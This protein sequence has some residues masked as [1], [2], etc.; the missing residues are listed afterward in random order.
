M[1]AKMK[2]GELNALLPDQYSA[3]IEQVRSL[4]DQSI[5]DTRSLI[6]DLFVHRSSTS[7][8]W[9]RLSIGWRSK[10]TRNTVCAA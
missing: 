8:G 9:R 3:S 10:L 4:L 6:R 7:W 1:L 2:L 5:K